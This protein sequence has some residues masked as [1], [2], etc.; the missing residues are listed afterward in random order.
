MCIGRQRAARTPS[1]LGKARRAGTQGGAR[2]AEGQHQSKAA[3]A[4]ATAATATAAVQRIPAAAGER[5]GVGEQ[6]G[7]GGFAGRCSPN[8]N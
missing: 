5:A 7:P 1:C 6:R 2:A 4:A 8:G 3:A